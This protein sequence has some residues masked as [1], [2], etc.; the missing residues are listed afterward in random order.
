MEERV[1]LGLPRRLRSVGYSKPSVEA[2]ICYSKFF[3]CSH[4]AVIRV[5][6]EAGYV[7]ETHE[8]AS[9]SSVGCPREKEIQSFARSQGWVGVI[10]TGDSGIRAIFRKLEPSSADYEGSSVVPI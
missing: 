1:H 10:L 3:N 9:P 7:I 2:R 4:N 5:Y 6:D 8:R